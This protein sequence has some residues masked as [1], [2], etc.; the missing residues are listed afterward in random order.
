VTPAEELLAEWDRRERQ[1]TLLPGDKDVI[2]AS[3][4]ARALIVE[5]ALSGNVD[6]R[7]YD[8]CAALGR[9][10]AQYNGSPTLAAL[11]LDYAHEAL[12][13]QRTAWMPAARAAVLEGFAASLTDA[14]WRKAMAFCEFPNCSVALGD[15]TVAI[16]ASPPSDDEDELASWAARTARAAA[17]SGVRAARVAGRDSARQALVE[18]LS[19]IGIHVI[20]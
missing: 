16:A 19:L 15:E 1:R 4:G 20:V 12:G 8:A 2:H 6:D 3:E 10:I 13:P 11:T 5:L 14:T 17:S 7:L 18:A 9:L